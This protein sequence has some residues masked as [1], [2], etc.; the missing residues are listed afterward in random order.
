ME[1]NSWGDYIGKVIEVTENDVLV[2]VKVQEDTYITGIR[3]EVKASEYKKLK[4]EL[5]S[6]KRLFKELKKMVNN[7][8][9]K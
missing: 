6:L 2:I 8:E 9:V 1:Q 5:D 4:D 7:L 3:K